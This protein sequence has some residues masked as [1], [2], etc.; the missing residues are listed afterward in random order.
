MIMEPKAAHKVPA[1]STS[2]DSQEAQ[3]PSSSSSDYRSRPATEEKHGDDADDAME[4]SRDMGETRRV[5]HKPLMDRDD[6]TPLSDS[7]DDSDDVTFASSSRNSSN[8]AAVTQ[9]A[10]SVEPVAETK[11]APEPVQSSTSA[12]KTVKA[13]DHSLLPSPSTSFDPIMDG[14]PW[15][16]SFDHSGEAALSK[17]KHTPKPKHRRSPAT[18]VRCEQNVC[19]I[20]ALRC[21]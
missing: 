2:E 15:S 6:A 3:Q 8:R 4:E 13:P 9:D 16:Q 19:L 12:T 11:Q 5:M 14:Q 1:I 18:T 21:Q 7:K 10:M 17:E 20:L